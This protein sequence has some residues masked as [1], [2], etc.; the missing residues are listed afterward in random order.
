MEFQNYVFKKVDSITFSVFSPKTIKKMASAKIVTPEL[1]DKEGYPV[2]GGLMDIRLGVI[3]PGLKCKTCGSKLKECI[4]HF[5]YIELARPVVHINFVEIVLNLLKGTCKECGRALLPRGKVSKILL[6]ETGEA[7][8]EVMTKRKVAKSTVRSLK[9]ITKCPHCKAKQP[10]ISIEKPTTFLENEKRISP[11][12]V[13]SRLEKIP[14]ED[15]PLFGID[16]KSCRPE[17]MILTVLAIP[18]V[19]MRPSIT[20]ESG[21]R[22]EDDLTHKLGDIVRINQRLFENINAG[23]PEIIIEDLW[24]LLQYHVTTF[25][26]NNVSQLP[27]ARHRSGQPLKTLSERIKSKEGRIRHNLA[28]KRTNFSARTVISPDPRIEL[29]EVG[30]PMRV[31]MKL[32]IPERVTEWN[33]EYLKRFVEKGP[34]KYPGSNYIIRPDG[35]KKKITDETREQLLEELQPGYIVER[36]LMD[37]DIAIFNRQPSLH[38]MSMMCHKI[39]VL[40][41]QTFRLNPA[42]CAPYNADFDG[43]EMN[44]HVPQNEESRAEAEILMLIQTQIISPRYGLSVMGGIQDALSGN[45]ML[46]TDFEVTRE[47]AVTILAKSG[48]T[49]FSVLPNNDNITGKELFSAIIPKDFNFVGTSR[50]GEKVEIKNGKLVSGSMDKGLLGQGQG[51]LLR[52]L[53]KRYG[54]GFAVNFLNHVF[55]LGVNALI[56]KGFSTNISDI[57]LSAAAIEKVNKIYEE[58]DV[59]VNKLIES[60]HNKELLPFPGKTLMETLELKILETLNKSRNEIGKKVTETFTKQTGMLIM[61]KSGGAGGPLN[62]AQMSACVGQQALRGKRI[63]KGFSKRTL[64]CF[65]KNDLSPA[66][67]GFISR[68]FKSGLKPHEFFFMAMT[69][70][71]SQMDTALRTPKSGYLYRRLANAMQDLKVEYDDTVRDASK[72]IVQFSYGEDNI[73]VSKSEKGVINVKNIIHSVVNR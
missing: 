48:I 64:S 27:P 4:G 28:G 8:I 42:V 24:D 73:D 67:H 43:D 14:D 47:Q 18:P 40:P 58:T 21:E 46:T 53:H 51:L 71:D 52:N 13:R 50:S 20:L 35:K 5:G 54:E 62:I 25:F 39:K 15:L 70:R 55:K 59:E 69:G 23:A 26:N 16:P 57:D 17:W 33:I 11:I 56:T 2:D 30:V 1:Y 72:K 9:A 44:L 63:E 37:G 12:E 36:H 31:A 41:G 7:K 61:T 3:D 6:D 22:S 65:K 29:N 60:F 10:K 38:R 34:A 49:D 68:G 45:F 66:A 19:T 32:T